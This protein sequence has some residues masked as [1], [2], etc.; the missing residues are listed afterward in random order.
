MRTLL[1]AINA[2]DI[3]PGLAVRQLFLACR[4]AKLD[5][6]IYEC[7]INH[8]AESIVREIFRRQPDVVGFSCYIW[9]ITLVERVTRAL[10]LAMPGVRV[11]WGGP[12]VTYDPQRRL[13]DNPAVLA[14]LRG[15]GEQAL[16][17]ALRAMERGELPCGPGIATR[18]QD[19]GI[20]PMLEAA[21]WMDVYEAETALDPHKLWTIETVRGCPYACS[22]C[23]SSAIEGLRALP[24][25]EAVRRLLHLRD[26]GARIVKLVDRTF[27]YDRQRARSI[28]QALMERGQGAT[29]HFEIAAN[30]LQEEDLALLARAPKGLFQLEVGVQTTS[31]KTLAGI[32][33]RLDFEKIAHAVR[34]LV[35]AGNIQIHVDL[36]AGLP[37]D[38]LAD[39]AASFDAVLAL[40]PHRVQLGFL[41]LLHGSALRADFDA[42]AGTYCPDAPYEV[43]ASSMSYAE[44]SA[45]KDVEEAVEIYYNAHAFPI[46]QRSYLTSYSDFEDLARSLRAAGFFDAGQG[47]IARVEHLYRALAPRAGDIALLEN[48]LRYD[49]LRK[50]K[51]LVRPSFMNDE[52]DFSNRTL[53]ALTHSAAQRRGL[54]AER[55]AY[56]VVT[57]QRREQVLLFDYAKDAVSVLNQG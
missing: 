8:S 27:N 57:G 4:A 54:E 6:E 50:Q 48:R 45:L 26:A 37:G 25:Q 46:T 19:G 30:L 56:D 42:G 40:R 28:W 43:I 17:C 32:G 52:R 31:E 22:Y 2:R 53:R 41:K 10:K 13:A 39:F 16:P 18:R 15:E 35:A 47:E 55:F 11:L 20:A 9:N 12:E 44:L 24:A 34:T 29:Y 51:R 3:H 7:D 5:A 14:V 36:I 38:R 49:W 33:R 21:Q 1:V 23:L